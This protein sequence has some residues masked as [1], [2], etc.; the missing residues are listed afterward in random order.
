MVS[1]ILCTYNDSDLL[2]PAIQSCLE[3]DI[4]LEIVLVDDAS[5]KKLEKGVEHFIRESDKV[6]YIRHERNQGLSAA[7]NT[8]ISQAKYDLVIPLDADDHFYPNVFGK[9]VATFDEETDIVYGNLW[10]GDRVDYPAAQ[11]FFKCVLEKVNPLFCSSMFRKR[12]WEKVG[13]YLVR[14]GPHYEDWN[15]WNK[16]FKAG[17]HFKYIDIVVYEHVERQDSML[18]K[19][20]KDKAKYV[21]I[22]T[23]PLREEPKE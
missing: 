19:L 4:E 8:G 21:D 20:E 22:A 5:T 13:G 14:E 18:R 12:V 1:V 11:P 17:A 3:Q 10:T 16:C 7:R 2:M 23:S 6:R 9:M 15:F